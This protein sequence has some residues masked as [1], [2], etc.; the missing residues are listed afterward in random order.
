MKNFKNKSTIT[1]NHKTKIKIMK[2]VMLSAAMIVAS[3]SASFAQTYQNDYQKVIGLEKEGMRNYTLCETSDKGYAMISFMEASGN[4]EQNRVQIFKTDADLK[5]VQTQRFV[6]SP[7]TQHGF[8]I[9][10]FDIYETKE[11][12]YIVAGGIINEGDNLNSGG[13]LMSINTDKYGK[14]GLDWMQI[15]P[16]DDP[17][18]IMAIQDLRRVVKLND[19]YVAIG[20]GRD[21]VSSGLVL[22]TDL[23]GNIQWTKHFYG[24]DYKG[25]RGSVMN[26]IV[27][28][29]GEEV[30]IVGSVNGFPNDDSDINIIR[31]LSNGEIVSNV[32][33]ESAIE[34]KDPKYTYNEYAAAVEY[35]EEKNQLIIAGTTTKKVKGVCVTAE[36]KEILTFGVDLKSG[37]VKWSTR[38]DI[39]ADRTFQL[40]SF[41]CA[42]IDFGKEDY[43]VA[44]TVKNRL[45]GKLSDYNGFILRLNQKAISTDVRFYGSNNQDFLSRIYNKGNDYVA[46]GM[47]N[48]S[49][50]NMNWMIESFKNIN[51]DC[52][53]K[54]SEAKSTEYPLHNKEGFYRDV[55]VKNLSSQVK[56]TKTGF[57]EGDLCEKQLAKPTFQQSKKTHSTIKTL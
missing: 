10:P 50:N 28:I 17:K 51:S 21:G 24:Q 25:N 3:M 49:G 23:Q 34:P 11:N 40:E 47:F 55:K 48:K 15:Y 22:K 56:L 44:G 9:T 35:N 31:L 32:I 54:R 5:V 20:H 37:A 39:G 46:G 1:L 45:S 4:L 53:S 14:F 26:D 19:G 43:A 13:F 36:Y 7:T 8:E 52:S 41:Y 12:N 30:A 57:F 38:H 18:G 29:N 16:N 6:Y 2:N 33:Y 42:D 27:R